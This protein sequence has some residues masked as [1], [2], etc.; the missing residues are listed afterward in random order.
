MTSKW[1]QYGIE[2]KLIQILKDVRTTV[3]DHHF[4]RPYLSAYQL[5]IEFA[6]RHPE[7][8][9]ALGYQL[10]AVTLVRPT[11]WRNIWPSS[12]PSGSMPAK[13]R[14]SKARSLPINMFKRWPFVIRAR[15]SPHPSRGQAYRW[16]C[17]AMSSNRRRYPAAQSLTWYEV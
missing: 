5:A 6:Q 14:R 13:S 4:G 11:A 3:P 7:V 15:Q 1:E 2:A 12:C 9:Q 10:G 16:R 8:V 17:F